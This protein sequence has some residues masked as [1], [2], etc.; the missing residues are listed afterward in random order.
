MF[1]LAT[2]RRVGSYSIYS[3]NSLAN[4]RY[5]W[6]GSKSVRNSMNSDLGLIMNEGNIICQ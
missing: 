1:Y 4:A 2:N 6:G 5:F 3:K